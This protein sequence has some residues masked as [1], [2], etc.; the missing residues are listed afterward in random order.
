MACELLVEENWVM[1]E[2]K[3]MR[4]PGRPSAPKYHINPVFLSKVTE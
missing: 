4:G 3:Q 1:E 2:R